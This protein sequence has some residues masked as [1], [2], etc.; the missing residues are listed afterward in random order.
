MWHLVLETL[1]GLFLGTGPA[2]QVCKSMTHAQTPLAPAAS[3]SRF[4][5]LLTSRPL[6]PFQPRGSLPFP[7]PTSRFK[8]WDFPGGLHLPSSFV[9]DENN[10]LPARVDSPY[11]IS[12]RLHPHARLPSHSHADAL[13]ALQEAHPEHLDHEAQE[14]R[15]E[16]SFFSTCHR[17]RRQSL[18]PTPRV[19]VEQEVCLRPGSFPQ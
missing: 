11:T 16:G 4:C 2:G 19:W 7:G 13:K 5:H 15:R 10:F 12:M 1:L 17:S 9:G 8:V 14:H 18:P 6:L 3:A